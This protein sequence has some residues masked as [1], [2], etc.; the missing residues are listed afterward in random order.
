[1]TGNN[2]TAPDGTTTA[3]RVAFIAVPS[4]PNFSTVSQ[5]FTATV[6][7]YTVSVWLRGSVGGELVYFSVTPG[8]GCFVL[9]SNSHADDILAT[10][11]IG[12]AQLTA[13]PWYFGIGTDRRDA[14][15]G[16][17]PAYTAFVWGAQVDQGAFPTSYI[18]TTSAAVTR[19]ADV[20]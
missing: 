6:A 2:T 10:I 1:M 20:A 16:A 17:T 14:T 8:H 4:A 15:Q 18:P 19:A 11:Y 13:V 5:S 12:D 3:S 9:Q 7:P